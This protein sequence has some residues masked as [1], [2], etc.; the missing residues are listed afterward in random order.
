[1]SYHLFNLC[2]QVLI[3]YLWNKGFFKWWFKNGDPC[4]LYADDTTIF[5]QDSQQL[6]LIIDGI[7]LVG[8]YSGLELNL[9]KTIAYQVGVKPHMVSG[10]EV[11]S[12]PVKYLGAFL[13]IIDVSEMNFNKPLT[14]VRNN[15][16]KWNKRQKMLHAR[17]LVAKTFITSLFIHILN[18][19]HI[20]TE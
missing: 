13:D 20:Q 15:I 1:M 12:K 5:V 14:G 7:L 3:F 4:S 6:S 8:T 18:S 16:H 17:V 10:V 9:S 19:V 2:H 11:A